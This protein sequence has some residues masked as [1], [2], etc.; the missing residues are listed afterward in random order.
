MDTIFM[1]SENSRTSGYHVL[2][3]KLTDKLDLSASKKL[4][5]HQKNHTMKKYSQMKLIIKNRKRDIFLQKKGKSL[6]MN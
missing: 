1:N 4:Q 3:L 2:V 6:L 5:V